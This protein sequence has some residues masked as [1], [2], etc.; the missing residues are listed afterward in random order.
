MLSGAREVADRVEGLRLGA[1]D[2]IPKPF[3]FEELAARVEAVARRPRARGDAGTIVVA[4]L[5]IDEAHRTVERSGRRLVLTVKEYGVLKELASAPDCWISAERLLE[6]VW[7]QN[8]DPFTSAVKVTMS[9]L[10]RKLGDPQLI[11]T[12]RG[13][14]YRLRS[15]PAE[16]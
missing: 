5:V 13:V 8:T 9:T 3:A 7:D 10:R 6:Q 15:E 4:G 12:L 1:D 2:Y 16:Q 14:G 11:E